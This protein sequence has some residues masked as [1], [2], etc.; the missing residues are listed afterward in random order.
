MTVSK[1]LIRRRLS[2]HKSNEYRLSKTGLRGPR[3]CRS[4]PTTIRDFFGFGAAR[5]NF[6]YNARMADGRTPAQCLATGDDHLIQNYLASFKAGTFT[7][8]PIKNK[9]FRGEKLVIIPDPVLKPGA[10]GSRRILDPG[11]L[12]QDVNE[13]DIHSDDVVVARPRELE[14]VFEASI[15]RALGDKIRSDIQTAVALWSALT[16]VEWTRGDG[17]VGLTFRA[18]GDVV[19]SLRQGCDDPCGNYMDWYC[20]GDPGVIRDDIRSA[21]A[22]EGWAPK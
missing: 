15:D 16:N 11:V 20:S 1:R 12:T 13:L 21:L 22:V 5:F 2:R 14:D 3:A 9:L 19:A 6:F 10:I 4:L 7:V 18:A 17:V 8:T